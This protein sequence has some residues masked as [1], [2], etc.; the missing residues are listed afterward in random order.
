[1]KVWI[2]T[3]L[4]ETSWSASVKMFKGVFATPERAFEDI[5]AWAR[6]HP[7][8]IK[9]LDKLKYGADGISYLIEPHE[10]KS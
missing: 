9:G 6:N 7:I 4:D 3:Y 8:P 1:M 5:P 2:L 10:I